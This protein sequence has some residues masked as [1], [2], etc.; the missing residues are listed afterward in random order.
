VGSEV[1]EFFGDGGGDAETAGGVLAV[2]D[3]EVDGVGFHDV[4]EVFADDVAAGGAKD[5]ADEEDIHFEIL[6]GWLVVG[7]PR[8]GADC[9]NLFGE[10]TDGMRMGVWVCVVAFCAWHRASGFS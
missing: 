6:H 1:E 5:V 9:M 4:G 7:R 3:E 10:K 2:D 8:I